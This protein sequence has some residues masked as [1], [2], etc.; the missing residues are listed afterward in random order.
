VITIIITACVLLISSI[1]LILFYTKSNRG[2][3]FK[4]NSL[5]IIFLTLLTPI[6]ITIVFIFFKE[7]RI[8][9]FT[10]NK[11][12]YSLNLLTV[13]LSMASLGVTIYIFILNKNQN[14]KDSDI[15]FAQDLI[16]NNYSMLVDADFFKDSQLIQNLNKEF[17]GHVNYVDRISKE[18]NRNLLPYDLKEQLKKTKFKT[19]DEIGSYRKNYNSNV[20]D[21]IKGGDK[22]NRVWVLWYLSKNNLEFF[23]QIMEKDKTKNRFRSFD[24][25]SITELKK[26]SNFKEDI[27][28][29]IQGIYHN[30]IQ[31]IIKNKVK[32]YPS[33]D[34]SKKIIDDEFNKNYQELGAF[35]R[36][37]YRVIKFINKNIDDQHTKKEL[38]GLLRSYYPESIL[39]IILYN[40]IFTDFGIGYGR[41]LINSDF[42]GDIDDLDV[43]KNSSPHIRNE[44]FVFSNIGP[45]ALELNIISSIFTANSFVCSEMTKYK[46]EEQ[47]LNKIKEIYADYYPL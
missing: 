4:K 18:I 16:K 30:E 1:F 38:Y 46:I 2:E 22:V 44:K 8:D 32:K 24:D 23:K 26:Y 27:L 36:N 41:E 45:K 13:L 47:L 39:L 10:I 12:V 29:E 11:N 40:S 43:L 21:I 14:K 28:V 35:I 19:E 20:T 17:N 33:F 5:P 37:S 42:F 15:K 25:N 34:E 7:P 31:D 9:G 6:F 3:K